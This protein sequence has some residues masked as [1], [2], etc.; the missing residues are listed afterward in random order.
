MNALYG[1]VVIPV[2]NDWESCSQLIAGID[3]VLQAGSEK[4]FEILLIDDGS[5]VHADTLQLPEQGFENIRAISL[6]RLQRNLGHQRAICVGLTHIFENYTCS[7]LIL[8]DSDGEDDPKDIPRLL[9]KFEASH[10]EKIVFA[11]RIKRSEDFLFRFF[12]I[13]YKGIHKILTG[14][15]ISIGN[16]SVIPFDVLSSLVVVPELWS[17]YAASVLYAKIPYA[18]VPVHREKRLAGKSKMNFTNLVIHGL[19]AIS[20]FSETVATRVLVA[21]SA[22]MALVLSGLVTVFSLQI[23]TNEL[24]TQ[25]MTSLGGLLVILLFQ[26]LLVSV[27]FSVMI[28]SNRKRIGFIPRRDYHFFIKRCSILWKKV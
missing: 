20:V 28:L 26:I 2:Y 11:R 9:H 17:H 23:F 3:E 21:C 18:L 6:L 15:G 4:T 1:L 12:L 10:Q 7:V 14:K 13:V 19:S 22:L 25:W 24:L 16:F 27:I 8:M 5:T